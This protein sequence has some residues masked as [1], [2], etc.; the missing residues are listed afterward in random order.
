MKYVVA[1]AVALTGC[2]GNGSKNSGSGSGSGSGDHEIASAPALPELPLGL[3]PVPELANVTPEN[4]AL[5]ALLFADKRLS[6][7]GKTACA[8]C[9]DPAHGF[10]GATRQPT[11]AGKPNLRRAPALVNLA[12]SKEYGWDG[13][14]TSLTDQLASHVKGQLG[15]LGPALGK[16]DGE[17]AVELVRAGGATEAVAIA[18]LA[19][20]VLTRYAGDSAW[21]RVERSPD[22]PA[23]IKAGYALFTGKA[24]CA[25]CH[26]PPLYTDQAYHRLGLIASPD[27]GRGRTDPA[28]QGAFRTPTVRGAAARG[29][30][31][32][33][34]SA[35]SLDAAID[36]HLAGGIGQGADPSIVD[37]GL[38]KVALTPAERAQ[39]GAFVRA[40]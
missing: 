10:A 29:G 4:T 33:D 9:H 5:G 3:P 27:D 15:E 38:S 13:R 18:G 8:T 14:Y 6:A 16:L 26:A 35:T 23:E 39:L 19:A 28:Q 2:G 37:K 20:Y 17:V 7:S 30:F 32:H 24:Q 31:F 21:D 11:D 34:A 40:L 22:A 25:T 36:W 1:I 12:W